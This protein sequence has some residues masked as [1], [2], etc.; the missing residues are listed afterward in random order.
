[1]YDD[2][3]DSGDGLYRANIF[4]GTGTAYTFHVKNMETS[5]DEKMHSRLGHPGQNVSWKIANAVVGSENWKGNIPKTAKPCETCAIGKFQTAK[6]QYHL[7]TNIPEFLSHIQVDIHGPIEP[8]SGPFRYFMIIICR[9]TRKSFLYLLSS[10]DQALPQI[11]KFIIKVRVQYPERQIK[12]IRFDNAMEFTSEAMETFL[13]SQGIE[14]ET[15]VPYVHAQN[16]SAEAQIKR[17]QQVAR[18]LLMGS[19]LPASAWGPAVLHANELLQY[20]PVAHMTESPYQLLNGEK[21]SIKHLRKFGCGVYTPIPSPKKTKLGMQRSLG[22]YVGYESPSII[23][24]LEPNTGKMFRARFSDCVFDETI[25]PKVGKEGAVTN[26]EGKPLEAKHGLFKEQPKKALVEVPTDAIRVNKLVKQIVDLHKMSLAAP[27]AF[28]SAQGV[29][30]ETGICSNYRNKPA[31][32]DISLPVANVATPRKRQGRPQGV[33]DT[34]PRKRRVTFDHTHQTEQI[35]ETKGI[36]MDEN[37]N[38]EDYTE[39]ETNQVKEDFHPKDNDPDPETIDEAKRQRSWPQ[40]QRAIQEELSSIQK[41]GVLG[42]VQELPKGC[43]AIG[44]RMVL[45][46]KRDSQGNL[47]RYKARLVAKGYTQKLGVDYDETYAPVMDATTYRYLIA[48]ATHYGLDTEAMDVVTAYLYGELDHDMWMDAPSG[49]QEEKQA[50]L[51]RPVVRLRKALYGLKQSGRVWYEKLRALLTENEYYNN[52]IAPC[53]FVKRDETEF[54]IVGVYVDDLNIMG[55]SKAVTNTKSLHEKNFEM[56]DL[57]KMSFCIGFQIEHC[58]KGTFVHQT[59]YLKKILQKF[60]MAD[61]NPISTP[62]EV[63]GDRELYGPPKEGESIL[64]EKTPYFLP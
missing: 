45:V 9:G 12:K 5:L 15:C 8:R 40:W 60:N 59:T 19:N 64:D 52:E 29:V 21:P 49:Y 56:K 57:G 4:P 35:P 1:M 30:K 54:A 63:R 28:A 39:V 16:G 34:H 62:M 46:K 51:K 20:R 37:Q 10:K 33:K 14:Q 18:T 41:R 25:S 27:D 47:V 44:Q 38:V 58:S 13:A 43:K 3:K 22:I 7:P 42:D 2:F 61:S 53:L 11:V 31:D 17:V 50:T 23:K 6:F 36:V 55:T 32:I 24:Y 48:M 26:P